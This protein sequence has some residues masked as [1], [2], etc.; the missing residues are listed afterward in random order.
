MVAFGVKFAGLIKNLVFAN[1]DS[2]R[3][4]NQQITSQLRDYNCQYSKRK[5]HVWL[6]LYRTRHFLYRHWLRS[7]RLLDTNRKV[8]SKLL[9]TTAFTQFP[10]NV[11]LVAQ[12]LY[13]KKDH[14][15]YLVMLSLLLAQVLIVT[16]SFIPLALSSKSLRSS[17]KHFH[18]TQRLL[19][20]ANI[21]LKWKWNS[22]Y[23]MIHTKRKPLAY[24]A[25]SLGA[26][27][28]SSL[29][30]VTSYRFRLSFC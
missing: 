24:T 13:S 7:H 23:E 20:K 15:L 28:L 18:T 16:L 12:V 9:F 17:H 1:E 5:I 22:Y 29:F 3:I 21:L 6:F 30:R 4:Y 27:T 14:L 10:A 8:I 25:G 26:I 19:P 2:S 11:Y